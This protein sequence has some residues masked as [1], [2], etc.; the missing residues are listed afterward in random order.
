MKGDLINILLLPHNLE[1]GVCSFVLPLT[2]FVLFS[3]TPL[4]IKGNGSKNT[5]QLR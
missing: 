1:H 4:N 5:L 3:L 2:P